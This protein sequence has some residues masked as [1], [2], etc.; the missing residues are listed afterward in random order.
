MSRLSDNLLFAVSHSG[1]VI[2]KCLPRKDLNLYQ[3]N[4]ARAIT[5]AFGIALLPVILLLGFPLPAGAWSRWEHQVIAEIASENLTPAARSGVERLLGKDVKLS[6]ISTWAD[7]I[8]HYRSP[9]RP[10]HYINWPLEQ[11]KPDYQVIDSPP[12]NIIAAIEYQIG[13]LK[14]TSLPPEK[15]E[16]AL[17]FIVHFVGDIHQP[18][19]CAAG[20]DR[21]GNTLPVTWRGKGTNFHHVWDA[22]LFGAEGGDIHFWA[23]Y[24]QKNITPEV[25]TDLMRGTS[26]DWAV[27]SHGIA[28]DFCYPQLKKKQFIFIKKSLPELS[29]DYA[30]AARPIVRRRIL[31][32]GLRLAAVL[33]SIF[34]N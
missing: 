13:I 10:W 1:F 9:T 32:A 22:Y 24:L 25:R 4:K 26:Y 28:R 19:H 12:T 21:G 15:R 2:D 17:K 7:Y 20:F 34:I 5:I 16:E 33:N 6:S 30:R 27:E 11:G 23:G 29:G 3:K 8:R 31:K 18:L 14:D